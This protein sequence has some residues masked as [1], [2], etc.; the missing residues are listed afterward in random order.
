MGKGPTE[1]MRTR[2]RL[3]AG[4]LFTAWMVAHP[5][6]LASIRWWRVPE[7]AASLQLTAAQQEAIDRVYE[8]RLLGRRRCVERL[9]EAS[10]RVDHLIK[11][12]EYGEDVLKETQAIAVAA[13]DQRALTRVLNREI[14][15]L[16]SPRQ[17]EMLATMS[18]RRMVE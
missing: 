17:R 6:R 10:N 5:I 11:N 2:V 7:V 3:G 1:M 14:G 16:L 9:V 13:G 8:E 12:G 15:S 4:I 18:P